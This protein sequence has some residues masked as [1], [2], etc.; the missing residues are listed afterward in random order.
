SIKDAVRAALIL[1][2]QSIMSVCA[3]DAVGFAAAG[4]I[5]VIAPHPDDETLGCGAFIARARAQ[6]QHVRI[7]VVTD[8]RMAPVPMGETG[9]RLASLRR[10]ELYRATA[11]LGVPKE[12]VVLLNVH[13]GEAGANQA[14]IESALRMQIETLQPHVVVSPYGIDGHEDHRAIADVIDH[15]VRTNVI[16]CPVLEYPIWYWLRDGIT[17]IFGGSGLRRLRRIPLYGYTGAKMLAIR[18]HRSQ[19]PHLFGEYFADSF[20]QPLSFEAQFFGRY[21]LFFEKTNP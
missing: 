1:A 17:D 8:G 13:D 3:R 18:A 15:L 5:L 11:I 2:F 10:E 19:C 6:R 12:D 20:F 9:D 16:K 7:V 14:A 4:P 21:E